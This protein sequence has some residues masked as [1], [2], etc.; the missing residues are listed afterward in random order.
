MYEE[1]SSSTFDVT[2]DRKFQNFL[3]S[4]PKSY[5]RSVT[6]PANV[7]YGP[8]LPETYIK[9]IPHPHSAGAGA[10][11]KIIP[12]DLSDMNAHAPLPFNPAPES[13]PWAP[14]R[15]RADFEYTETAVTGL[16]SKNLVNKQLAGFNNHWSTGGSRLTIATYKDM[17]NSLS[18][19]RQYVVQVSCKFLPTP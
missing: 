8:H 9:I 4:F 12:L 17:Q 11:T 10:H 5:V 19:A 6:S 1:G 13:R 3:S 15:T 7:I 2:T 18:K 14:F 16:L